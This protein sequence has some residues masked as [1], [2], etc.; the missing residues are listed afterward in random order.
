MCQLN[1][2][3][4]IFFKFIEMLINLLGDGDVT[5]QNYIFNYFQ[6]NQ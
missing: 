2:Q 6:N 3:D 5:I 4:M 1:I